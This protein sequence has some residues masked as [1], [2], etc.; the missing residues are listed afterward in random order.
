[1]IKK[2]NNR[3]LALA[4]FMVLPLVVTGCKKK[5]EPPPAPVPQAK[6]VAKAQLPV[7]K[8][9]TSAQVPQSTAT[10]LDFSSKK[11]PFKSFIVEKQPAG[12]PEKVVSK[13]SDALPIQSF[14]V[15]AFKVSGIIAGLKENRALIVDPSGKG[16]V[17][18]PGMMIGNSD[19]RITRITASAIEVVEQYRDDSGRSRKRTVKLTLSKKS[20]ETTR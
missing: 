14:D 17:V 1:M 7:Q 13:S 12:K 2:G 9:R 6:P 8:Q 20:K 3:R 4:F 10:P 16:Y 19:G 18:K 15:S 5:S 11:D